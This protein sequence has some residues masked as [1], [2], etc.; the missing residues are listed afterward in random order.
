[1]TNTTVGNQFTD[2]VAFN[3]AGALLEGYSESLGS[4]F[5]KVEPLFTE[6]PFVTD[7][8]YL[9]DWA[10]NIKTENSD[11][12]IKLTFKPNTEISVSFNNQLEQTIK[13]PKVE[14][15]LLIFTFNGS[16]PIQETKQKP[17]QISLELMKAGN[18]IF[19]IASAQSNAEKPKFFLPYYIELA[20][21]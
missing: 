15:G 19:G 4:F 3:I 9:G 10:G 2:G 1:M 5:E 8:S 16:I 18:K 7:D 13:K 14:S 17:H 12:P 6:K 11:F 20:K 21:Q